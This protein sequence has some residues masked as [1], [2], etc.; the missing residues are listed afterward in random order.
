MAMLLSPMT[1][2][3][4]LVPS[5]AVAVLLVPFTIARLLVPI[6]VAV[7]PL[8]LAMATDPVPEDV[9]VEL[10]CTRTVPLV[11]MLTLPPPAL[12]D[13]VDVCGAADATVGTAVRPVPHPNATASAPTLPTIRAD[14]IVDSSPSPRRD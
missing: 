10:P 4:L 3:V 14:P 11:E 5:V 6:A 1:F 2:A 13:D 12:G 8:P 7:F 9:T